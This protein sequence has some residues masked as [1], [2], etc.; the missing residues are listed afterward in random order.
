RCPRT[1][2]RRSTARASCRVTINGTPVA[3]DIERSAKGRFSRGEAV[4]VVPGLEAF[5]ASQYDARLGLAVIVD[6]GPEEL[7]PVEPGATIE[8]TAT[9]ADGAV[10]TPVATV[11][12]LD[13]RVTVALA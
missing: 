7:R 10:V 8:C 2:T 13:G 4:I 6:C 5:V 9:D 3:L 11:E 12:D 1:V